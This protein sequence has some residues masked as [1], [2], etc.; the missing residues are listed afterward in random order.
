LYLYCYDAADPDM[1]H[2]VEV[3]RDQ[4]AMA[5]NAS[6]AW[7]GE[8]M[9]AAAPPIEGRPEMITAEPVWAKGHAL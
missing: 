2:M 7:F 8:Y 4:D 9:R 3:Y 1:I 6:G 5:A